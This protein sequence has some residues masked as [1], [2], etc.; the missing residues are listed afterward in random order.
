MFAKLKELLQEAPSEAP[1]S[2]LDKD[3]AAAALLVE[4]AIIDNEFDGSELAEMKRV[5]KDLLDIAD[6]DIQALIINAQNATR[7][8]TSVYEFTQLINRQLSP[9]DKFDLVVGM[10]R[11]AYA[12]GNL[13]KYEEYIIRKVSDLIYV[14]HTEFIR[15]KLTAQNP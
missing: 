10:W 12:D 8:A 9:D 11:I 6:E 1:L 15:A 13:D 14:P 2:K 5:L 4:V 7:D 3:L